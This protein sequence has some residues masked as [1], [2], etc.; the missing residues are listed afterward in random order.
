MQLKHFQFYGTSKE[1]T[2]QEYKVFATGLFPG[3]TKESLELEYGG[4]KNCFK[5]KK[6]LP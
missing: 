4:Y 5:S 1:D 3:A 6:C 2:Y